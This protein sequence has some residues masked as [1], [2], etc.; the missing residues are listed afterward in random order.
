GKTSLGIDC[1]GVVQVALTACGIACPRDSEM[2]QRALGTAVSVGES[3][4]NLRRGDLV[5]WPGHVAIMCDVTRIIHAN[6]HHMAVTVEPVSQAIARIRATGCEVAPIQ[7]P[8][9]WVMCVPLA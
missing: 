9:S 3:F 5:F 2:Q 7:P 1:S 4:S 6:A 8:L